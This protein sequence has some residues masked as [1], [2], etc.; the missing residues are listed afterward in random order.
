MWPYLAEHFG[1]PSSDH[2]YGRAARAALDLAREQVAALIGARPDEIVFTSGGTEANNLAIRG[3]AARASTAVARHHRG[4]APRHHRPI[5][6]CSPPT[7]GRSTCCPSTPTGG[8]TLTQGPD[9]GRSGW[10]R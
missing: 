7:G 1:N 10:P 3:T 4:R 9:P 8:P 5:W 2:P 6:D